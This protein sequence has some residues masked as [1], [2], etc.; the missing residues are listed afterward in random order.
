MKGSVYSQVYGDKREVERE[1]GQVEKVLAW[2]G[3]A[4]LEIIGRGLNRIVGR[5]DNSEKPCE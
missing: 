5:D 1:A 3:S 2:D 4:V